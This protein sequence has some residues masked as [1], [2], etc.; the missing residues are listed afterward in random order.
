MSR[1]NWSK[2]ERTQLWQE[3]AR[4]AYRSPPGASRPATEKQINYLK[5]LMETHGAAPM[6]EADLD[7]LT[8]VTASAL[9]KGYASRS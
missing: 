7:L 1:M 4:S 9:I 6:S 3:S 2:A 5:L 8:T